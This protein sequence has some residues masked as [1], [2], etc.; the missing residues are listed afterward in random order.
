MIDF[1]GKRKL[2]FGISLGLIALT[3]I[4]T[5]LFSVQLDIQFKGGSITTYS[6]DGEIDRGDFQAAVESILNRSVTVQESTLFNEDQHTFVVTL[7]GTQTL[8]TDQQ[9]A[10]TDEL[11]QRYP[12]NTLD[13][14][15]ISNVDPVIGK[16]F[17]LK[18]IIAVMIAS[19]FMICYVAF[20][21]RRISGLSAGVMA[22]IALLHDVFMVF[23]VFVWLRMPLNDNFI[24][25]VL[26]ILGYSLNDTIV[27]YDRIRENSSLHKKMPIGELVN[28]SINQSFRRSLNTSITT[29]TSMVIVTIVAIVFNVTSILSFSFPMIVGMLAGTYSSICIA[30]PLWVTWR[31][32]K[33]KR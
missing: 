5:L 31:E 19:I 15:S 32:Y 18:S 12:E 7:A 30:G 33:T 20:R 25:V 26:T 29:I 8:S 13:V 28:K 17:L 14:I 16:E 3:L 22:V 10:L 24:A 4:A 27:I 23:A 11:Q 9:A 1:I 2:F 21:F 6:Y